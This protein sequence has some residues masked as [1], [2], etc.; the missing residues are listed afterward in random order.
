MALQFLELPLDLGHLLMQ[1]D[2]A[3]DRVSVIAEDFG[4]HRLNMAL[5]ARDDVTHTALGGEAVEDVDVSIVRLH[6]TILAEVVEEVDFTTDSIQEQIKA[7]LQQ[8][9]HLREE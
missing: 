6:E 7:A 8:L 2:V 4:A 3:G 5:D 9:I 1:A